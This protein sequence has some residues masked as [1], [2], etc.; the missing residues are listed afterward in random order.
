MANPDQKD[1][2]GDNLGDACPV[3]ISDHDSD[4]VIDARDNC[5]DSANSD[6]KDT[7]YDMRG[8]ACNQ[9]NLD[10][11]KDGIVNSKDNCPTLHDS[12]QVYLGHGCPLDATDDPVESNL[13]SSSYHLMQINVRSFYKE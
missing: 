13:T 4:N 9:D 1:T 10:L 2:D 5:R 3:D 12:R 7:D 6:Q 8:D 11:D